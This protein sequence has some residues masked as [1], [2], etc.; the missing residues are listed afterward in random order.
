MIV[1]DKLGGATT[2]GKA[3]PTPTATTRGTPGAKPTANKNT[4]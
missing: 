4:F 3:S 1:E 2:P